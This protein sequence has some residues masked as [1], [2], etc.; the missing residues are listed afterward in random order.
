MLQ[1]PMTWV[2]AIQ[3]ASLEA[4]RTMTTLQLIR[5]GLSGTLYRHRVFIFC[6][7]TTM[8]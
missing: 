8:L 7:N 4:R 2:P 3:A 5:T 1:D 6:L